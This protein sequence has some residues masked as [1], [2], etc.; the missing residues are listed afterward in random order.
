MLADLRVVHPSTRIKLT[1]FLAAPKE[2]FLAQ[3]GLDSL[4]GYVATGMSRKSADFDRMRNWGVGAIP[5]DDSHREHYLAF[6]FFYRNELLDDFLF[7][8]SL[9]V[10]MWNADC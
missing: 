5:L 9:T 1:A 7:S 6:D 8:H 2:L 4:L 10:S 3:N